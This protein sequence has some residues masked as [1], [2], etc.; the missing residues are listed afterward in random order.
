MCSSGK[1]KNKGQEEKG[2]ERKTFWWQKAP[3]HRPREKGK[4]KQAKYNRVAE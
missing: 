1:R 2:A 4:G 3:M